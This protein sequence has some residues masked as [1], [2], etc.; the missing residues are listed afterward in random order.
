MKKKS[1][2]I[3]I[4]IAVVCVCVCIY[5]NIQYMYYIYEIITI[6]Y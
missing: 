3:I 2:R 1:E 5:N 4:V 6:I